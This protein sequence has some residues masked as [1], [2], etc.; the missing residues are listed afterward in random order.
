MKDINF[1]ILQK[2]I[3]ILDKQ[4]Y[5]LFYSPEILVIGKAVSKYLKT[6]RGDSCD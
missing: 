5:C 2:E 1:H 4:D 6:A 3:K